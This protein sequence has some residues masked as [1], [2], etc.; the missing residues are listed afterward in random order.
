[1]LGSHR[2]RALARHP[3]PLAQEKPVTAARTQTRSPASP[4]LP[5]RSTGALLILLW[6]PT[7]PALVPL[8]PAATGTTNM[9][10]HLATVNPNVAPWWELTVL[11]RVG[12]QTAHAIV[13][14]RSAVLEAPRVRR[15][16]RVFHCAADL[17]H[18][19]GIGPVTVRRTAPYL[20]F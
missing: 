20:R 19:R 10:P 15:D 12:E 11:P 3:V 1:M 14:Y 5:E 16:H 18:V 17:E 8:L 13:R 7:I 2:S 9:P 4:C 6:L